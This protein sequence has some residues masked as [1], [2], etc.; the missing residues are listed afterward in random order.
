MMTSTVATAVAIF[1]ATGLALA[2][3]TTTTDATCNTPPGGWCGNANSTEPLQC[4]PTGQ[5]CSPVN[6]MQSFCQPIPSQ[7]PQQLPQIEYIDTTID[8]VFNVQPAD[9]CARCV[10]NKDCVS[11]TYKLGEYQQPSCALKSGARMSVVAANTI[12]GIVPGRFIHSPQDAAD[13][14]KQHDDHQLRH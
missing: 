2:T 5:A 12:S 8:V 11:Y 14:A 10:A 4:C 7:C 9:C 1:A 3:A 13:Q 6:W